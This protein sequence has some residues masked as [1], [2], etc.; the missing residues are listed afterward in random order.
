MMKIK[1]FATLVACFVACSMFSQ[2][3]PTSVNKFYTD[4]KKLETLS[5]S[6][7]DMAYNLQ[8]EMSQCF[9]AS[10]QSGINIKIDGL[11]EMSSNLYTM[12]LFSM[13]FD[14]RSLKT[15]ANINRTELVEQP[16]Q[17]KSMQKEGARHYVT[18][19]TKTYTQNGSTKTYNDVVFTLR[20]NGLITEMSNTEAGTNIIKPV[21][22]KN[23][24]NVEQLRARAAYYYSKGDYESAYSYYEQLMAKAPYDG[25]AAYR[26]ALLTFWRKGCKS[27]FT[28][29]ASE[30]KAKEYIRIAI[31]Y[32]SPDISRKATNVSKNWE[33]NNV[34][35]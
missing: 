28:K 17:N 5:S 16:D 23:T 4:M 10:E 3:T 21:D 29:K 33:N 12:R 13:I 35:F 6:N 25:D 20:S 32:G 1:Y 11:D 7:S 27:K 18:Y 15:N 2:S 34:Y 26:I 30:A 19:I 8:R 24:L 22:N 14:D 9:M 31:T